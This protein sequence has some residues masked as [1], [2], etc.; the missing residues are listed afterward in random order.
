VR[1]R[2]ALPLETKSLPLAAL[3]RFF[4]QRQD[5]PPALTPADIAE[6]AAR[7]RTDPARLRAV[8]R[9]ES[10][11]RGFHP[12]TGLPIIL[13]EPHVFHRET[14]GRHAAARPDLSYRSWGARA[15]PRS[16]AERWRQLRAAMALDE[17]AALRSA[18]WGLFQVMGFNHRACGFTTLQAFA[19][20]HM[21]GERDQL[22]AFVS[23]LEAR[24]LAAPLREGRWADFARGYNG[25][26]YARHAYDQRLKAADAAERARAEA[27]S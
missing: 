13:F 9:V 17:P 15:Y 3:P 11:G 12:R 19:R 10:A 16:Q 25:A 7:L 21:R 4:E 26:A 6:A 8:I 1:G 2:I 22:L 27:A 14:R 23:F 20:A 5:P 18:S 24:D